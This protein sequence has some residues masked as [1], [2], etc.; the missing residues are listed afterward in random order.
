MAVT[1]TDARGRLNR[2]SVENE[3]RA[4]REAP[5]GREDEMADEWWWFDLKTKTAVSEPKNKSKAVDRLG[6]YATRE[7]AE[8]ALERVEKR[9]KAW[10]AEDEE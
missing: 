8:R 5:E 2:G 9:N 4:A 7:E 1:S 6:P 10:D 3:G